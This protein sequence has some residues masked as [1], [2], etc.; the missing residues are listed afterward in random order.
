MDSAIERFIYGFN[1][2][3]GNMSKLIQDLARGEEVEDI[4]K[5]NAFNIDLLKSILL[6]MMHG[7]NNKEVAQKLG[8]HRV[9]I[10]RYTHALK[11]LKESEFEKIKKYVLN[12]EN[13][14]DNNN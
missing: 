10:Q 1:V 2:T 6:T 5:V 11:K 13:E 4:C 12:I 14:E 3:P 7:F 9:T 8:V